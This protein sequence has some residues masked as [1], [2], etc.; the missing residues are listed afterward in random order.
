TQSISISKAGE[1]TVSGLPLW[2]RVLDFVLIFVLAPGL[3]VLVGVVALLVMCGSH[4]P[5]FFR[6][7]RVGHKGREFTCYKFRT[8]HV[9]AET[10]SHRGHTAQLIKSDRKS[11]V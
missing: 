6:Q 10:D 3:L 1:R 7:R 2:K 4:G 11:V 5:I 9:G 8:M